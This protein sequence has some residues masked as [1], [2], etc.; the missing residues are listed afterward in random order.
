MSDSESEW[1]SEGSN[2]SARHFDPL[3][4]YQVKDYMIPPPAPLIDSGELRQWLLY[5]AL[6]CELVAASLFQYITVATVIGYKVQSSDDHCDGVGTLGV[7]WASGGMM[8]VLV[9]CN[10]KI[11]GGHISVAVTF[12]L[13]LKRKVSVIRAVLYMVAQCLGAILGT[14]I[15]KGTMD[16]HLYNSSGGGANMVTDGYSHGTA[17]GAE[18]I[19][20]FILVFV[21]FSSAD[22][23]RKAHGSHIPLLLSL[24]LGFTLFAVHS[25]TFPITGA[26]LNPARSFGAAVIYNHKKA[27]DDHWIFWVGPLVG[28][29]AAAVYY[30]YNPR[31]EFIKVLLDGFEDNPSN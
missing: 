28:A 8:F 1:A 24:P 22:P 7:A 25:A 16:K 10:T 21:V 31:H 17:L 30:H 15:V 26:G 11:S 29:L 4:N 13:L 20:T 12:G 2:K 9:Y 18:I 23:K 3:D 5:R 6:V 19:G 27:W 14:G